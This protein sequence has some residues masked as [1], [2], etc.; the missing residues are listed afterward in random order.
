MTVG[1][2]GG[3]AAAAAGAWLVA[4]WA[5]DAVFDAGRVVVALVRSWWQEQREPAPVVVLTHVGV[6]RLEG[7][8]RRMYPS[9]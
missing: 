3:V 2:V 4:T 5:V 8:T 9:G 7:Q 6:H 1:F